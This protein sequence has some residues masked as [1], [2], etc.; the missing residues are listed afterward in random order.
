MKLADLRE[1]LSKDKS[2][3]DLKLVNSSGEAVD[4]ILSAEYV[5]INGENKKLDEPTEFSLDGQQVPLRVVVHCW[6]HRESSAADYL[7]DCQ[8]KQLT[9]VSFLQRNDLIQWLSGET[10]TSQYVNVGKKAGDN[11]KTDLSASTSTKTEANNVVKDKGEVFP[12]ERALLD[13][14]SSLRG[15]KPTDFHYLIKEAELKLV[16]SFKTATKSKGGVSKPAHGKSKPSTQKDPII[17]IPSAASSIFTIAN[18]KQFLEESKYINPK[19][20]PNSHKDLVTAV[21]K[22][23]RISRSIKFLIVNNTKLFTQPEYWDRVVAV[24]TTGHEW[25]FS[26]YQWSNP[27]ELFQHCKGFY[28][29]FAGDLVPKTAEQWNV[30]KVQLDKNKRF[31]D[32]EVSRFFWSIIERELLT[33]GYH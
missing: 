28:F 15:S 10:E 22:F 2:H 25:Q 13:H 27:A 6:L 7:A 8:A 18:I 16:H 33:R 9:N 26:N 30:Q 11:D 14:N 24:F 12:H 20:L 23:D 19:D 21:K 32:I 4:D 5:T 29:H 31:R 3:Q 17:L 1:F